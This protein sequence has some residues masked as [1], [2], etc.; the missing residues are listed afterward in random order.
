MLETFQ[1]CNVKFS[2]NQFFPS[3]EVYFR[4]EA[5]PGGSLEMKT[6]WVQ[7]TVLDAYRLI[8][9]WNRAMTGTIVWK[10]YIVTARKKKR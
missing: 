7:G 5:Y 10:Y 8:N 2:Y 4:Q 3:V 1:E 6:V 9:H